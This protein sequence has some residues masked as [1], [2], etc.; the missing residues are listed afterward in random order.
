MSYIQIQDKKVGPG[1]P[2]YFIADIA[3]N[4]DGDLNRAKMLIDLAKEAGADAV[5]FQHFAAKEIV[6]DHGFEKLGSKLSHQSNWAKSVFTVYKEAEVPLDWTPIL[7]EHAD[8]VGIHFFSTPYGLERVDHLA[9]YVPAFKIGSGDINWHAMLEKVAKCGKPVILSTG[10]CTLDEVCQAVNVVKK[11]NSQ[12]LLMQCNTNYTADIENFKHIHLNVLK[13][14]ATLFPD[15]VLGL[16]DHTLGLVTV[17]GAVSLSACAIEKHF[18]DDNTREGP[19][20]VFAMNPKTWREMV[21]NTRLLELALGEPIKYVQ[22]NEADT[23][24]LQRR[25]IRVNTS[26]P[27]GSVLDIS[28]LEFQRPAPAGS[29]DPNRLLELVGCKLVKTIEEGD[30]VR[31]EHLELTSEE[32]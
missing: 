18:T 5:K 26:L 22:A 8:R 16:S 19:D 17:L 24:H 7:K 25:S 20:H 27:A 23:V 2:V 31:L 12:V 32:N 11:F 4:H 9:P 30:H 15:V 13:T 28:H 1:Y 6:S 3:A 14:Y 29:F 10:A 21:D